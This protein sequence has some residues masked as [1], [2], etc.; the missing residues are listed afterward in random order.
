MKVLTYT[1]IGVGAGFAIFFFTHMFAKEGSQTLNKEWQEETN[2]YLKV[3]STSHVARQCTDAKSDEPTLTFAFNNRS[4]GSSLSAVSQ[5]K[6]TQERVW[7]KVRLRRRSD[8]VELR[9]RMVRFLR[10]QA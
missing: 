2:K 1:I 10:T 7:C 3:R 4:S 5:V 6:A 9:G 8:T